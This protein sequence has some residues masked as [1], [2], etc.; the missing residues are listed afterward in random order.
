MLLP[1]PTVEGISSI[2]TYCS[3]SRWR[4]P[5]DGHTAAVGESEDGHKESFGLI[6][7]RLH[8]ADGHSMAIR[9]DRIAQ[10]GQAGGVKPLITSCHARYL[11]PEI[12]VFVRS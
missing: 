11:L 5:G 8:Q 10:M 7:T 12:C 1:V 4:S 3:R 9:A 6:D 2:V